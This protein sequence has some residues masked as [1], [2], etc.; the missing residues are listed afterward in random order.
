[1]KKLIFGIALISTL[2][3]CKK[4][5]GQGGRSSISGK[6][7]VHQRLYIAGNPT[8]T[9]TYA[10]ANQDLYIV[11]G[12][13]DAMYDDKI[14]VSYDG[15][16][17]F[18]YLRPGTYTIYGYNEIFSKGPN[19]LNNDDDYKY[20]EPVSFT[21]SIGKKENYDMGTIELIRD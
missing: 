4:T 14:E 2:A 13:E 7:L 8:D 15:S 11:Y 21:V 6:V 19:Q 10:G 20:L 17:K 5:E 1:M 9:L 3:A 16:F 18:E 12:D